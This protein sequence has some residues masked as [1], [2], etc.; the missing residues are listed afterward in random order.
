[1]E[2]N[3]LH[4]EQFLSDLALRK[5][6][7]ASTQNQVLNALV[8]LY[9]YILK[10]P[11]DDQIS[12]V[13][14]KK[15]TRLPTVFTQEEVRSVLAN[16]SGQNWL[17][18]CLLYGSGL[19][20]MEDIRLRVKDLDF[21]HRAVIVRSGKGNKDRVVTLP[22]ELITILKTHLGWVKTLHQKDLNEGYGAVYLPN[23]LDRK[24]PGAPK[25]WGWQCVF[26]SS[27]ISK[28]PRTDIHCRHHLD[29]SSLQ[30]AVKLAIRKANIIKPAS[31]HTFRHSFATH[32]LERG[33]DIRTVQEQ[34]G[35]KDLR[36]TQLYTH[37]IERGGLAVRSPLSDILGSQAPLPT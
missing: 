14:A 10:R 1:M 29:E 32:L 33:M 18:A 13:R 12:A 17:A 35:H 25:E 37:I 31:C 16:L 36:T 28:D 4:V 24:Y 27:R 2:M 7:A 22:D 30:K 23:A 6:V 26:P 21:H 11:L 20:L 15:P 5:N 8:F 9:R 34:L 19:R 3:S